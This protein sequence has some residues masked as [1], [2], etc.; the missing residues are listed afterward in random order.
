MKTL[1][2]ACL[3][4]AFFAGA[5]AGG[6]LAAASISA[7]FN[8][9]IVGSETAALRFRGQ[10]TG[11][12]IYLGQNDL[13]VGANRDEVGVTWTPGAYSFVWTFD[14]LTGGLDYTGI[15]GP[16][17]FDRTTAMPAPDVVQ[18][19]ISNRSKAT[20]TFEVRNLTVNGESIADLGVVGGFNDFMI[21]DFGVMDTLTI[22][23]D[24]VVAGTFDRNDSER[25][26]VQFSA[27]RNP[28]AAAIPLPAAL[29][30]LGAGIGALAVLRR[31]K[32]G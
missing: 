23:G 5:I 4:V 14:S 6:P 1:K 19:T 20:G 24:L 32:R 10:S 29:P 9:L 21:T 7:G 17:A 13:G 8:P 30:L 31:R 22:A 16:L 25:V 2:R 28:T 27:S 18:F 26:R 15:G 3:A 12:E 11:N